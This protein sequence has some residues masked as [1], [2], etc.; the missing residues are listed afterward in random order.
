VNN[1]PRA[2]PLVLTLVKN[3]G[4]LEPSYDAGG[5]A[6]PNGALHN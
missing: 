5:E 3:T 2:S 4:T 1:F 6:V